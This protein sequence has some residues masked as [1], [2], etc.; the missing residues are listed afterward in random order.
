[1][2]KKMFI[3]ALILSAN[4]YSAEMSNYSFDGNKLNIG[5]KQ[6][7]TQTVKKD[8]D[9]YILNGEFSFQGLVIGFE[10]GV[11]TD[12]GL[13]ISL[14]KEVVY[15]NYKLNIKNILISDKTIVNMSVNVGDRE[16]LVETDEKFSY[17]KF[18]NSVINLDGFEIALENM[19]LSKEGLILKGE[20][21]LPQLGEGAKT[22][23]SLNV[24]SDETYNGE[25]GNFKFSYNGENYEI[26]NSDFSSNGLSLNSISKDKVVNFLI[27]T[28]GVKIVDINS[29]N[30]V[31]NYN[32]FKIAYKKDNGKMYGILK[33]GENYIKLLNIETSGDKITKIGGFDISK[34]KIGDVVLNI[35]SLEI[36]EAGL[37]L[38]GEVNG[39]ETEIIVDNSGNL[40][41]YTFS[42]KS[43]DIEYNGVKL[44]LTNLKFRN[45]GIDSNFNVK[46]GDNSL[47]GEINITE[48]DINITKLNSSKIELNGVDFRIKNMDISKNGVVLNLDGNL[49]SKLGGGKIVVDNLV[50]GN[51]GEITANDIKVENLSING[52]EINLISAKIDKEAIYLKGYSFN[53]VINLKISRESVG[54]DEVGI[55][56]KYE[57][58]GYI[59]KAT[60]KYVKD[61]KVIVN[62]LLYLPDNLGVVELKN[63]EF[64]LNGKLL[65][66]VDLSLNE[67]ELDGYRVNI[68]GSYLDKDGVHLSGLLKLKDGG[69]LNLSELSI[70][71]DGDYIGKVSAQNISINGFEITGNGI[72][73]NGNISLAGI[74][75]Y[76][77]LTFNLNRLD[78]KNGKL[79]NLD[80]QVRNYSFAGQNLDILSANFNKNGL[81]IK[82]VV[83]LSDEFS[84]NKIDVSGI[85]DKNGNL[86]I[87]YQRLE[88]KTLTYNGKSYE[89]VEVVVKDNSI[90]L[91]GE[92]QGLGFKNLII[93]KNGVSVETVSYKGKM[94]IKGYSIYV[95]SL[96]NNFDGSKSLDGY[97]ILPNGV[98]AEINSLKLDNE[99]NIIGEARVE[100]SKINLNGYTVEVE[101]CIFSNNGLKIAGTIDNRFH[102]NL[103]IDYSGKVEGDLKL[104]S[105]SINGWSFENLSGSYNNGEMILNG[106]LNYFGTILKVENVI[107]SKDLVSGKLIL[108]KLNLYGLNIDVINAKLENGVV[109]ING[110]ANYNGAEILLNLEADSNGAVKGNGSVKDLEYKGYKVNVYDLSATNDNLLI[111]GEIETETGKTGINMEFS[112]NGVKIKEIS[113]ATKGII[114]LSNGY[115]IEVEEAKVIDGKNSSIKGR[116]LID[117][118]GEIEVENLI[119]DLSNRIVKEGIIKDTNLNIGNGVLKLAGIKFDNNGVEIGSANYILNGASYRLSDFKVDRESGISGTISGENILF[120][121]YTLKE[122]NGKLTNEKIVLNGTFKGITIKELEYNFKLKKFAFKSL[123]ILTEIEYEG[124]KLHSVTLS[125]VNNKLNIKG[126]LELPESL[127]V[128]SSMLKRGVTRGITTNKNKFSLNI[129]VDN[130]NSYRIELKNIPN[131][132][133]K[134]GVFEVTE[135]Y[136]DKDGITLTGKYNKNGNE[137]KVAKLKIFKD[138]TIKF[139]NIQYSGEKTIN[140]YTLKIKDS[141]VD[142]NGN[143]L[144]NGAVVIDGVGEIEIQN[145]TITPSNEILVAGKIV[146]ENLKIGGYNLAVKSGEFGKDGLTIISGELSNGNMSAEIERLTI[147]RDGDY[148][149]VVL[150]ENLVYKG[151]KLS[152]FKGEFKNGIIIA[153][154]VKIEAGKA[155]IAINN[156]K[157]ENG[158]VT[159]DKFRV[160]YYKLANL[161]MKVD[162]IKFVNGKI[163]FSGE[164]DTTNG[165]LLFSNISISKSGD[166][167]GKIEIKDFSYRNMKLESIK[168]SITKDGVILNGILNSGNIQYEIA[169]LKVSKSGVELLDSI[170]IKG[171]TVIGGFPIK[172]EKIAYNKDGLKVINGELKLPN[173]MGAV[174]IVNLKVNPKTDKIVDELEINANLI[175]LGGYSVNL[176]SVK[177]TDKGVVA[178][179]D[180]AYKGNKVYVKNL[181]ITGDG[182]V[183]GDI[184]ALDISAGALTIR[185]ANTKITEDGFK[186][187]GN[188]EFAGVVD[189][190][191]SVKNLVITKKGD[192][193]VESIN[194]DRLEVKGVIVENA[195]LS[196]DKTGLNIS[197]NLKIGDGYAKIERLTITKDGDIAGELAL[198]SINYKGKTLEVAR[199]IFT[200]SG[201]EIWGTYR[202]GGRVVDVEKLTVNKSGITDGIVD[203]KDII[204]INGY[205]VL[206]KDSKYNFANNSFEVAGDIILPEIGKVEIS[207]LNI[208][209][210]G[211]KIIGEAE[212]NA[213]ELKL[214]G[215]TVEISKAKL[216]NSGFILEKGEVL[217]KNGVIGTINDL[218]IYENGDFNGDVAISNILLNGVEIKTV[219]AFISNREGIVLN[220]EAKLPKEFGNGKIEVVN[221]KLNREGILEKG[222]VIA[223]S[224]AYKG[225]ALENFNLEFGYGN[226]YLSGAV[227]SK[228]G[229][230]AIEDLAIGKTVATEVNLSATNIGIDGLKMDIVK[231]KLTDDGIQITA[232]NSFIEIKDMIITKDGLKLVNAK[233]TNI[234]VADIFKLENAEVSYDSVKG[235]TLWSNISI[236]SKYGAIKS[237][238]ENVK[239]TENGLESFNLETEA[240]LDIN[241]TKLTIEKIKLDKN[242]IIAYNSTL[243]GKIFNGGKTTLKEL[244]IDKDGNIY[245][246]IADS[247]LNIE[248]YKVFVDS[249]EFTNNYLKVENAGVELADNAG[250]ITLKNLDVDFNGKLLKRAEFTVAELKLKG[251]TLNNV[252][253]AFSQDGLEITNGKLIFDKLGGEFTIDSLK[254][255]KDKRLSGKLNLN[256]MNY[257]GFNLTNA[258]VE[259]ENNRFVMSDVELSTNTT[260]IKLKELSFNLN[261]EVELTDNIVEV[262]GNI[263]KVSNF[264][265]NS[266]GIEGT[267]EIDLDSKVVNGKIKI[268]NMKIGHDGRV[269]GKVIVSNMKVNDMNLKLASSEFVGDG[270]VLNGELISAGMAYKVVN[271]KISKD[272]V[273]LLGAVSVSG[274][275]VIAGYPVQV[276]NVS[277]DSTGK[278]AIINGILKLPNNVGVFK[279]NSLKL[280]TET[281]EIVEEAE[282]SGKIAT[283]NGYKVELSK[284]RFDNS[285]FYMSGD[286]L[287]PYGTIA[288]AE[289]IKV[290]PEGEIS[291]KI[292]AENIKFNGYEVKSTAIEVKDREFILSGDMKLPGNVDGT[293]K[294]KGLHI[295]FNG[296]VKVDSFVATGLKA[297]GSEINVTNVSFDDTGLKLAGDIKLPETVGGAKAELKN[298]HILRDGTFVGNISVGKVN[299]KNSSIEIETA[300][301]SNEYLILSGKLANNSAGELTV[302]RLMVART[303]KV[304][305]DEISYQGTV[306]VSGYPVY[307]TSSVYNP[308]E[309]AYT[310]NGELNLNGGIVKINNLQV[311]TLGADAKIVKAGEIEI[312]NINIGRTLI[313]STKAVLDKDGVKLDA[314]FIVDGVGEFEGKDILIKPDGTYEGELTAKDIKVRGYKLD[315]VS[316][317]LNNNGFAINGQ[318]TIP[319][320]YGAGVIALNNLQLDYNGGFEEIAVALNNIEV[321]GYNLKNATFYFNRD[322]GMVINATLKVPNNGLV[323]IENIE[324]TSDMKLRGGKAAV[325]DIKVG[326]SVIKVVSINFVKEGIEL[327]GDFERENSD[328]TN[329]KIGVEKVLVAKSGIDVSGAYIKNAKLGDFTV[330]IDKFDFTDK[331]GMILDGTIVLPKSAG[332]GIVMV[333]GIRIDGAKNFSIDEISAGHITIG[334]YV[335]KNVKLTFINNELNLAGDGYVETGNGTV[336]YGV[337]NILISKS[338]IAIDK[339]TIQNVDIDGYHFDVNN[340]SFKE[341]KLYLSIKGGLPYGVVIG[342]KNLIIGKDSFDLD[343]MSVENLKVGDWKVD[344]KEISYIKGKFLLDSRIKLPKTVGGNTAKLK[345]ELSKESMAVNAAINKIT[346]GDYS[347]AIRNIGYKD[348]EFILAGTV[349]I[350]GSYG[351]LTGNIDNMIITKDGFSNGVVSIGADLNIKGLK[352]YLNQAKLTTD[353]VVIEYAKFAVAHIS[354]IEL[355]AGIGVKNLVINYNG[356]IDGELVGAS[357]KIGGFAVGFENAKLKSTGISIVKAGI[358]LPSPFN[359]GVSVK[360][361]IING[362]GI[363][364]QGG[365]VSLPNITVGG[366]NLS[367]ISAEFAYTPVGWRVVGDGVLGIPGYFDVEVGFIAEKDGLKQLSAKSSALMIPLGNTGFEISNMGLGVDLTKYRAVGIVKVSAYG[368]LEPVVDKGIIKTLEGDL[369]LDISTNGTAKGTKLEG[370]GD[371]TIVGF[372]MADA[373][374]AIDYYGVYGDGELDPFGLGAL[375]VKGDFKVLYTGQVYMK[376]S[377]N[378]TILGRNFVNTSMELKY[379]DSFYMFA[380]AGIDVPLKGKVLWSRFDF[381]TKFDGKFG[382][383]PRTEYKG[384]YAKGD[385]HGTQY[386]RLGFIHMSP[387]MKMDFYANSNRLDFNS[388]L[389]DIRWSRGHYPRLS[390]F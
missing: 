297:Y 343:G 196:F 245:S 328:G 154:G 73:E 186:I 259:Y 37:K 180:F 130:D 72:I 30:G 152:Q 147:N 134:G 374:V 74:G 353:G 307:I 71:S 23:I 270:I 131:L 289:N 104:D 120:G 190:K 82:G 19:K 45:S 68:A 239:I 169:K 107:L 241:G 42:K 256:S 320:E 266:E 273:Q 303:G 319:K 64:D 220:G 99:N 201:V 90:I 347:I 279:I 143:I 44:N 128:A 162:N 337:D 216:N 330:S 141:T 148:S 381:S 204:N 291:G 285:G 183:T 219:E 296:K 318:L 302:K 306:N 208:S 150:I 53:S 348:G 375:S 262:A 221:V 173:G 335:I 263:I 181:L 323:S 261:G 95:N 58:G 283:F 78:Y 341:N 298:L 316:V 144:I 160:G 24:N 373:G 6:I 253:L 231:A 332:N 232:K 87:D 35:K 185:S 237:Q 98:R 111:K 93:T 363:T 287:F 113:Y 8:G 309:G 96:Y 345:I 27:A 292:S 284:L 369:T 293:I 168:A 88:D 238:I 81:E 371:V 370:R 118:V 390:F 122:F 146:A 236:N 322:N 326:S 91:T 83:R 364:M 272:G 315:V 384:G 268:E 234:E 80:I 165:V 242:R 346:V 170:A 368:T 175:N 290:T 77:E 151:Y 55:D 329:L 138:G 274:D 43:Y 367:G 222:K 258:T 184:G 125:F 246:K 15:K 304:S 385:A 382:V 188:V 109:D 127:T 240:D 386:M 223:N 244:R 389:V 161:D 269:Y 300:N 163:Q 361:L 193:S 202:D 325:K 2:K 112:S 153:S 229:K 56:T 248:G 207:N 331:D 102:A 174:K 156:L 276:E 378:L 312:G 360:N 36:T 62:G 46:L 260:K 205:S 218:E 115:S 344:V 70:N 75:K 195:N 357:V 336:T 123:N 233:V 149:G 31:F 137:L 355:G 314:K 257:K 52:K 200:N 358:M 356:D 25:I 157:I 124:F 199:A 166:Y 333:K 275:S 133:Y 286:I 280:N 16:I 40:V 250:T 28:S 85:F 136:I 65:S 321:S 249:V 203:Y 366:Y 299:Y 79:E 339:L 164:A 114:E 350:P 38:D 182:K 254:V 359:T 84:G 311:D 106:S 288:K 209:F 243:E 12:K 264:A 217:F 110:K 267:G 14:N 33:V 1:M 324:L 282:V 132:K 354:D 89:N 226:L 340:F 7:I 22:N 214:D 54:V 76:G 352:L 100:L 108:N 338:D 51:N 121:G 167:S 215:Y 3:A 351:Y 63:V 305:F 32:N 4:L 61:D 194:S 210:D 21:F 155:E 372:P 126:D 388:R 117:G 317:K 57:V 129:V 277:Y 94:N 224:I 5:N 145:L 278:I 105:V 301:F 281:G 206:V 135:S 365:K 20:I 227:N 39:I 60:S 252:D 197:G 265:I 211:S 10:N 213:K 17:F 142:S 308:S 189:G 26:L 34:F 177:L 13:D 387:S 380:K 140:G 191:I 198:N 101:N 41:S 349:K 313:K 49:A 228:Y 187:D 171:D 255:G 103:S 383:Y 67:I 119:I 212:I 47:N 179:G 116:V 159:I 178:T 92:V 69:M 334:N 377:G 66:N 97:L 251:M 342:V 11:L 48:S 139:E 230:F 59:L 86:K 29:Y 294:L 376:N 192:I 235:L 295:G 225:F 271:L 247:Y 172:V 379:D 158:T 327:A 310:I 18:E 362:N 9:S 50:I 176:K